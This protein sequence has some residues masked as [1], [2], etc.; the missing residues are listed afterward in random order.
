MYLCDRCVEMG[1][2]ELFYRGEKLRVLI[3]R[4]MG[5]GVIGFRYFI[6]MDKNIFGYGRGNLYDGLRVKFL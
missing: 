4:V 2:D 6:F 3:W 5:I 1:I